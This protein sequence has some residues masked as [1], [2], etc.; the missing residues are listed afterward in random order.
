LEGLQEAKRQ[1]RARILTAR[2][3]LGPGQRDALSAKIVARVRALP[4]YRA[5]RVVA[6]YASFGSE[7]ATASFLKD[8]LGSG[9]LLLLPRVDRRARVLAFHPVRDLADLQSGPWGIP[10]P[11]PARCPAA[12]LEEVDFMLVPGVAFTT[13]G[14]RLGYGGGY[15]DRVLTGLALRTAKIAAA[16]SVQMVESLPMAPGDRRVDGVLTESEAYGMASA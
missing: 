8:V 14:A 12:S 9:K 15:Y 2:E 7:L 6:A 10:E 11:D 3:A 5:A 1:L 4:A 13:K 16:F